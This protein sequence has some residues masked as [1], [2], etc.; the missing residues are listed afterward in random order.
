MRGI[1]KPLQISPSGIKYREL[2]PSG[3]WPMALWSGRFIQDMRPL[4][5]THSFYGGTE[6]N[7]FNA[8]VRSNHIGLM[9]EDYEDKMISVDCDKEYIIWKA[10]SINSQIH[11]DFEEWLEKYRIKELTAP[12][13]K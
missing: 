8:L 3:G 2:N 6:M 1:Q 7:I 5:Q 11:E 4:D 12:L 10:I 9:L 13:A